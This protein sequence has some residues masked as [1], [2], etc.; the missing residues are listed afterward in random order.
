M[1]L[2]LHSTE[3]FLVPPAA[4]NGFRSLRDGIELGSARQTLQPTAW[5]NLRTRKVNVYFWTDA[6]CWLQHLFL[7]GRVYGRFITG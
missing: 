6:F 5:G 4:G 7:A 2:R 3:W 1:C